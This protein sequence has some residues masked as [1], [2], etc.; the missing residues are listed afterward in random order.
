M[1]QAQGNINEQQDIPA[2]EFLEFWLS[3]LVLKP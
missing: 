1:C 3:L 2:P